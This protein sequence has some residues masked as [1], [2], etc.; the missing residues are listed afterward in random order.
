[1]YKHNLSFNL[2]DLLCE[3]HLCIPT[4][5]QLNS[6]L[7]ETPHV[8]SLLWFSVIEALTVPMWS[9]PP[10]RVSNQSEKVQSTEICLHPDL[11]LHR[12]F[13][14]SFKSVSFVVCWERRGPDLMQHGLQPIKNPDKYSFKLCTAFRWNPCFFQRKS[15]FQEFRKG[16]LTFSYIYK[17]AHDT[18]LSYK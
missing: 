9:N 18:F 7:C 5:F 12:I 1:M 13:S 6:P 4:L 2:E 3:I 17:T 16:I 10:S 15:T 14:P 11:L 8:L